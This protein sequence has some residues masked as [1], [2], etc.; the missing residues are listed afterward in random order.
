MKWF[1]VKNHLPNFVR[2]YFGPLDA[3]PFIGTVMVIAELENSTCNCQFI[4]YVL[5]FS[6][7]KSW[8]HIS[9]LTYISEWRVFSMERDCFTTLKDNAWNFSFFLYFFIFFFFV[10]VGVRS[11]LRAPRLIFENLEVNDQVNLQLPWGLWHSN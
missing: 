10:S 5:I 6:Q 3:D 4:C 11:S 7:I 1:W 2:I 8:K 9:I